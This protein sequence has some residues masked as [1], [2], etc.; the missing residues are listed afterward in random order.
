MKLYGNNS[1]DLTRVLTIHS[2]F[3]QHIFLQNHLINFA[4][5]LVFWS[6]KKCFYIEH[7]NLSGIINQA[8]SNEM[9]ENL[10]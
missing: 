4:Q 3:L 7:F 2:L 6:N 5:N 8:Y 1:T 10:T 9:N